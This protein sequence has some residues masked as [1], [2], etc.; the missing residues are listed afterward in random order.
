[1]NEPVKIRDLRPGDMIDLL[2]LP[3]GYPLDPTT[4]NLAECEFAVVGSED[5]AFTVDS[6]WAQAVG[7]PY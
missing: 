1:M 2:Q 3:S 7:A 6:A 4:V 5:G